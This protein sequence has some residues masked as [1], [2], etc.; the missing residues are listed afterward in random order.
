VNEPSRSTR[1]KAPFDGGG[2]KGVLLAVT[3]LAV[4]AFALVALGIDWGLPSRERLELAFGSVENL[5]RSMPELAGDVDR[6]GAR[7]QRHENERIRAHTRYYDLIRSY[8]SDEGFLLKYIA[9][10]DPAKFDFD[11]KMYYYPTAHVYLA[12]AA[13]K[14][15]DLAG[16][17]TIAT[18]AAYYMK[19]PDAMRPIYLVPRILG[20]VF[21]VGGVLLTYAV[22]ARAFGRLAGVISGAFL[23]ALPIWA[24]HAHFARLDVPC[25]FW[26]LAAIAF[27]LRHVA[28]P[29]AYSLIAA[30]IAAGLAAST[31][32]PGAAAIVPVLLAGAIGVRRLHWSFAW[33]RALK[34]SAAAIGGAIVAFATTS[35]FVLLKLPAALRDI[36]EY[37]DIY[38]GSGPDGWLATAGRNYA[39]SLGGIMTTMG[40]PAAALA[41]L[42]LVA[43]LFGLTAQGRDSGR[44]RTGAGRFVAAPVI[45]I[46]FVV[47]FFAASGRSNLPYPNYFVPIVPPLAIMGGVLAARAIEWTRKIWKGSVVAIVVGVWAYTA[48]FTLSYDIVMARKDVRVRAARWINENLPAK[49]TIGLVEYPVVY[50]APPFNGERFRAVVL[51]EGDRPDE[52]PDYV[53][54]TNVGKPVPLEILLVVEQHYVWQRDFED[55]PTVGVLAFPNFAR[56]VPS[57]L[58]QITPRFSLYERMTKAVPPGVVTLETTARARDRGIRDA[59]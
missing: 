41:G 55:L 20:L 15:A 51:G 3:G 13:L 22:A 6:E 43:M 25:A 2:R 50:R 40:Q 38:Y 36:T 16:L 21:A 56:R 9:N 24:I 59:P 53:L 42:G 19:N 47:V 45:L 10:M 58:G 39:A 26:C 1:K 17:A 23:A 49:A 37:T 5:T 33:R 11:P 8:H 48:L 14:A 54:L 46:G 28:R 7:G 29:R 52:L 18:D 31:K 34:L 32:Y 27:S 4:V 30:G 35:P 44:S 57:A 12:A